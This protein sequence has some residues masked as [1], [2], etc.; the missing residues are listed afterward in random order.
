MHWTGGHRV[1]DLVKFGMDIGEKSLVAFLWLLPYAVCFMI[2]ERVARAEPGQRTFRNGFATDL[3]H[4][5]LNPL[6]AA[7][8][9]AVVF[10]TLETV[11]GGLNERNAVL[12]SALPFWAQVLAAVWVGDFIGYWR[13]RL[14]HQR[15]GWPFHAV[16]HSSEEMD[17]LSNDRVD[18]V[19]NLVTAVF[20]AAGLYCLGFSTAAAVA[21]VFARRAYGLYIHCNVTWSYGPLDYVFV[22]PRFH[23]WHHSADPR[24]IDRNFTTFFSFLDWLFGT[25]FMPKGERPGRLGLV[26]QTMPDGYVQQVTYP[27]KAVW[28]MFWGRWRSQT[29]APG[30][31]AGPVK[32]CQQSMARP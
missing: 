21:Q 15:Y 2:V 32:D 24:A 4:S 8:I 29:T 23:R 27:Y 13:H 9:A 22:S 11:A 14:L 25:Y 10:A 5:F 3:L 30:T 12:I 7:P 28:K 19:E 18:V 20:A 6:L 1:E 17:W 26:H 16:H 31:P